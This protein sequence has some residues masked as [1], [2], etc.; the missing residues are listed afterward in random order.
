MNDLATT[1][2]GRKTTPRWLKYTLL[3]GGLVLLLAWS[4][5]GAFANKDQPIGFQQQ[6]FQVKSEHSVEI[7]FEIYR[8]DGKPAECELYAQA[9]DHT[10]VGEKVIQI[11]AGEPKVLV[12][13]QIETD[14]EAT[15]AVVK[16]CALTD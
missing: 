14:R 16:N 1:R 9:T 10:V 5:W 6:S 3:G 12:T 11:P 13:T 15:T 8:E 4:L 2:Y 7:V